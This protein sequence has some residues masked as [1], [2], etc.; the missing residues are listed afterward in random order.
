[1]DW[2]PEVDEL[3]RREALARE[4]GGAAKVERQHAAG[5]LTVRE[6]IAALLDTGSFHEI[7]AITGKASYA[8]DGSL[9][10]LVPANFVSVAAAST[11]DASRSPATTSPCAAAPPMPRSSRSRWRPSA[12]RTSCACRWCA[13]SRAAVAAGR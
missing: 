4:M 10:V 7:G 11:D 8:E 3:R 2:E 9:Q 5:R 6:R 12:W 1:V 13:W